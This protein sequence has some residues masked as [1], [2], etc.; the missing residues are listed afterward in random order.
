MAASLARSRSG[1]LL[2]FAALMLLG[3]AAPAPS[4][5][6][7]EA[8]PPRLDLPLR[9]SFGQDCFIQHYVDHDPGP[10]VRDYRCGVRSYDGHKGT[11]FRLATLAAQRRGVAVLAAADGIVRASRDG[12]ADRL[13]ADGDF[14]AV[15]GRECGNGVMIAAPGGWEL[16]YCHMALGSVRVV[17]GQSVRRGEPLGLVGLSGDAQFP[18][19]HLML[20]HEGRV[21]DPFA[22]DL[23]VGDGEGA[24]LGTGMCGRPAGRSFWSASA[25]KALAYREGEFINAGFADAP[26]TEE[27]LENAVL[28]PPGARSPMLVYYARAIGVREGDMMRLTITSPDGGVMVARDIAIDRDMA[29]RWAFIGKP[30]GAGGLARGLY[31]GTAVLIRGGRIAARRSDRLRLQPR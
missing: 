7:G 8:P 25:A 9:C 12:M 6:P 14:S 17:P 26:V 31:R 18:H 23:P 15:S 1:R 10:G 29:I 13:I 21:V 28:R 22:P 4:G 24:A 20:R 19:L 16:H 11:D 27:G 2:R 3:A 5:I 30:A